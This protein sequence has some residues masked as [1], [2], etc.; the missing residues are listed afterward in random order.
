VPPINGRSAPRFTL[1]SGP[2]TVADGG[3]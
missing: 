2:P 1:S 3:W